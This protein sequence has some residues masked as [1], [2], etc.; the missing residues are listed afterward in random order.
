M[1]TNYSNNRY[2]A[3]RDAVRRFP[4]SQ[5]IR[6]TATHAAQRLNP[7]EGERQEDLKQGYVPW[8][9]SALARDSII[10]GTEYRSR[11]ITNADM[12]KLRKLFIDTPV[13]IENRS[14][15]EHLLARFVQGIAHEQ[16]PYQ[17]NLKRELGR[18]YLLFGDDLD[19]GGHPLHPRPQDWVQVLWGTISQAL[20]ASFVF[21]VGAHR[22]GGI[23]DPS[24][25]QMAWWDDLEDILPRA[26]STTVLDR[27]S[28]TVELAKQDAKT[29]ITDPYAYPR[30][31]YNPLV[32]TPIM[33]LGP[34]PRFV[35][36][37]YFLHTAMTAENLYYKGIK[38]WD[39]NE[40]GR[41]VGLRVQDYVGRQ[42]KHTGLLH[43]EPEFRWTK[44]RVGGLDSSDWFVVTP[45]ATILIECKSARAN[46]E[47]R[48]GTLEGLAVTATRLKK[49]F[50]Q[51]N[52]NAVQLRNRN[53]K[54]SH[55]PADR[56]LIGLVVTAEP[57]YEANSGAV[58]GMLP[59]PE[60]PIFTVPLKDLEMLAVLPPDILG[61]ALCSL[62]DHGP[63]MYLL[64]LGLGDHL[65]D[66]YIVPENSLLDQAFDD[67]VLPRATQDNL[68]HPST[69]PSA[70]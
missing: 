15:Q 54:F 21:A 56:Q 29:V 20:T 61:D 31:A 53:P 26:A 50:T 70:L 60:I 35:P 58:R 7:F 69:P 27:L 34:G 24:W 17:N 19:D 43:V 6:M 32:S 1:T 18:S 28:S 51:L 47:M 2:D 40:F 67:A 64:S 3:F 16:F 66:G 13:G 68:F 11:T 57:I 10:Y 22:N 5:V 14:D 25:M 30:Y 12:N 65:P 39:R 63:E 37:P 44:K 46:P 48:S 38:Q 62:A 9:Y 8:F 41:A 4:P 52:E 42:L 45:R 49:A 36:Q 59:K 33:D 23:V 55:L